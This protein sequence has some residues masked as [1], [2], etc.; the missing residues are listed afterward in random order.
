[1][2][3]ADGHMTAEKG[4]THLRTT[5]DWFGVGKARPALG[6]LVH[7]VDADTASRPRGELCNFPTGPKQQ[8]GM[9]CG[10]CVLCVVITYKVSL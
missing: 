8:R 3:T 2:V 4:G 5:A 9:R 1:M 10:M 7:G 6:A